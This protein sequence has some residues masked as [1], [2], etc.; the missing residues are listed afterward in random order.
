[1]EERGRSSLLEEEEGR[2]WASLAGVLLET[3]VREG[4]EGLLLLGAELKKG[5]VQG[6]STMGRCCEGEGRSV[7][8]RCRGALERGWSRGEKGGRPWMEP[9]HGK[10]ATNSSNG[11]KTSQHHGST[12][13]ESAAALCA[14]ELGE[15][16]IHGSFCPCAREAREEGAMERCWTS[17]RREEQGG[18][19]ATAPCACEHREVTVCVG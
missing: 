19:A 14:L 12:G 4:E 10:A 7:H 13:N 11:E 9:V 3:G 5:K 15:G 1:M 16:G 8:G 17:P 2:R 6:G 18:G